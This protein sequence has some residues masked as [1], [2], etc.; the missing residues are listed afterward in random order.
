M[1]KKVVY[2]AGPFR[3]ANQWEQEAN[4]RRAEAMALEVWR[5]GAVALCPHL[6]TRYFSGALPDEVWLDGDL[7]LLRRCDAILMVHGWE[8]SAGAMAEKAFARENNIPIL[9]GTFDGQVSWGSI[10]WIKKS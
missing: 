4:I 8:N 3:A 6:N 9:N 10:Q 5:L 2:I 1:K 7:E